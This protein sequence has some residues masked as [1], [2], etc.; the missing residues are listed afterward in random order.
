MQITSIADQERHRS[1][2]SNTKKISSFYRFL[3]ITVITIVYFF[4]L[5]INQVNV[6]LTSVL[7]LFVCTMSYNFCA[8]A[9][10]LYRFGRKPSNIVMLK[11]ISMVWCFT[12]FI[13]SIFAFVLPSSLPYGTNVMLVFNLALSLPTLIILRL[14]FN[15]IIC[16][17][18]IKGVDTRTAIVIGATPSAYK[19]ANQFDEEKHLG[20]QFMG[21]YEDRKSNRVPNNMQ[22]LVLGDVHKALKLANSGRIDYVYIALPINAGERMVDMLQKFSNSRAQLNLISEPFV[23]SLINSRRQQIGSIQTISLF[24]ASFQEADIGLYRHRR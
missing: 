5:A 8:E 19:L 16:F 15:K 14:V 1:F 20:I 10:N 17:F 13:T 7:L 21:F 23:D 22:Y 3:D 11:T 2:Q 9:M 6:D 24:R 12:S 4:V 18:R